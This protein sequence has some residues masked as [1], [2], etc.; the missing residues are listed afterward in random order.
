MKRLHQPIEHGADS[1]RVK[2]LAISHIAINEK[3]KSRNLL[4]FSPSSWALRITEALR[5][6]PKRLEAKA[7]HGGQLKSYSITR[8]IHPFKVQN[9]RRN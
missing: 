3:V 5:V 2:G 6:T 1:I 8:F 4:H 9:Y 7:V